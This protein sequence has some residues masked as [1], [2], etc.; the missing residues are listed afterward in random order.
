M[1]FREYLAT[2]YSNLLELSLEHIQLVLTAMLVATLL[3]VPLGVLAHRS[4]LLRPPVLGLSSFFLT[5]PSFALFGLI[6]PDLRSRLPAGGRR[7]GPVRAAADRPQHRGA[8]RVDPAIVESAKGM[9]MR[10][11]GGCCA[12]SCPWRGRSSSPGCACPRAARRHRGDRRVVNGPGLG[13]DIFAG[14]ARIGSPTA[15]NLVL[16]GML[17]DHRPA[18]LFDAVLQLARPT[19]DFEGIR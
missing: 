2:N 1:T 7:A 9:G 15:L 10:R 11:P 5:I 18:V 14:L 8:A 16:G 4:R 13:D 17:G 19:D 3:G 12:S 6:Y